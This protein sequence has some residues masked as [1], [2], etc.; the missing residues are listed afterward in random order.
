MNRSTMGPETSLHVLS[1]S[2]ELIVVIAGVCLPVTIGGQGA[3][4]YTV[5]ERGK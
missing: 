5:A 1:H 3:W 2:P 4:V